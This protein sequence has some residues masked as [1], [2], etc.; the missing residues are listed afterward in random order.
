MAASEAVHGGGRDSDGARRG[1]SAA[2]RAAAGVAGGSAAVFLAHNGRQAASGSHRVDT[3]R[4][5]GVVGRDVPRGVRDSGGTWREGGSVQPEAQVVAPAAGP[6][7]SAL[8]HRRDVP[9]GGRRPVLGAPGSGRTGVG[10]PVRTAGR[11]RGSADSA[12]GV[13]GDRGDA[14]LPGI[15]DVR[16]VHQRGVADAGGHGGV[17]DGGVTGGGHRGDGLSRG[18]S[19]GVDPAGG[20]AWRVR[21]G[22]LADGQRVG[23]EVQGLLD[24]R[25]G[26]VRG[27][28]FLYE[29][30]GPG[31]APRRCS[32][33]LSRW[34]R[35][36][37][38]RSCSTFCPRSR[39]ARRYGFR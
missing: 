14:V 4:G 23:L 6:G 13:P 33:G 22:V 2:Y 37:R 25:P 20:R 38:R 17:G 35:W 34:R 5:G 39:G 21:G 26:G 7:A 11:E 3:V 19:D 30:A 18:R 15:S 29:A 28:V 9:G 10:Q 12:G 8:L 32:R 36:F 27:M 1:D 24:R 31:R 16:A